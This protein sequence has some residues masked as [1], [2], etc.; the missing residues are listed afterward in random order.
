MKLPGVVGEEKDTGLV[1][2]L[3]P[4][5]VLVAVPDPLDDV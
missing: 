4:C 3:K 5:V 1:V 2:Q